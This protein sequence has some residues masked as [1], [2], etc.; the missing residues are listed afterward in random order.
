MSEVHGH[1]GLEAHGLRPFQRM[2]GV[3][4]SMIGRPCVTVPRGRI[5]CAPCT[6]LVLDEP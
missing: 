2:Q 1:G 3:C 4:R 6:H 5:G